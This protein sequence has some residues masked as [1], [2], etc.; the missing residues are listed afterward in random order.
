MARD[1][2]FGFCGRQQDNDVYVIHIEFFIDNILNPNL[3]FKENAEECVKLLLT[4]SDV[5][6]SQCNVWVS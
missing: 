6:I 3:E 5:Y 2:P 1:Y 4:I